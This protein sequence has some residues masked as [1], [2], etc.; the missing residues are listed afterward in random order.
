M[1]IPPPAG[2][3]DDDAHRPRRIGLRESEPTNDWKRDSARCNLQKST[4]RKCHAFSLSV[5][6]RRL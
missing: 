3:A 6:E 1:S 2:K 4:A 5:A